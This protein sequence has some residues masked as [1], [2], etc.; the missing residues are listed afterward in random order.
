MSIYTDLAMEARELDPELSG[1]MEECEEDGD[2]KVTRIS[3][4]DERAAKKLGK[5]RGNYITIEAP[6]LILRPPELFEAVSAKLAEEIIRLFSHGS[7][8]CC[9]L[10][11]GLGN[12][13]VT[14]DSLGPKTLERIFVTRHINDQMPEAFGFHA[15][16]V[17]AS[18]PGVLGTTGIE[19][20]EIL[21]GM[22]DRIKPDALIVIDSLA[23]RRAAR[24][25]TAIQISDAG[26]DPGSGVGNI[27]K[28]LNSSIIGIPVISIGVPLVVYA[29][30]ITHDALCMVNEKNASSMSEKDIESLAEAAALQTEGLIVT[31]KDI[32]RIVEDMAGVLSKGINLALFGVHYEEVRELLS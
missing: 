27:R 3:I 16:S 8:P 24:I 12:K 4:K 22:T 23:S 29:S 9:V 14:P 31:P 5:R 21:K 25:S 11:A 26:I 17:A 32:D 10:I 19:T 13:A 2:I 7:E 30:T 20:A 1:V 6:E 18:A 28:G 15:V